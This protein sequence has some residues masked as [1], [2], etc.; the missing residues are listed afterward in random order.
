[1]TGTVAFVTNP[2]AKSDRAAPPQVLT[3]F[4][5]PVTEGDALNITA[6]AGGRTVVVGPNGSGKS[7]LGIRLAARSTPP[8]GVKRILGHRRLWFESA[9][10][11]MTTLNRQQ[12]EAQKIQ[13]GTLEDLRFLDRTNAQGPDLT[14]FD[15]FAMITVQNARSVTLFKSGLQPSEVAAQVGPEVLDQLNGAFGSGNI[16][17]TVEVANGQTL[18]ATK[19]PSGLS[20]EVNS[21][22]DGEKSI[23]L[24]AGEVLTAPTSSLIVIDEPERHLHRSISAAVIEYLISCRADAHFLVLTHDLDLAAALGQDADTTSLCLF[25]CTWSGGV[26]QSW[27]AHVVPSGEHLPDSVRVA[28]LGGRSQVLFVEGAALSL[29]SAIYQMLFPK[30]VVTPAGGG[31]QVGQA[32]RGL[33]NSQAHHWLEARGIVDGDERDSDE[34]A[35]LFQKGIL[36]L[37]VSEIENLYYSEVVVRAVAQMQALQLELSSGD[38]VHEVQSRGIDLFR[39]A[40]I[41]ERLAN[42]FAIARVRKRVLE[43]IPREVDPADSR[44][45][46]SV[47]HSYEEIR[48][49][50]N[51]LVDAGDLF[52]LSLRAPIRDVGFPTVVAKALHFESSSDY[53]ARARSLLRADAELAGALREL[54]A[55]F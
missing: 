7:A 51:A 31:D 2:L 40:N 43:Q 9:G 50:L 54:V 19:Q 44:L 23:F 55:R 26:A 28:V 41:V 5:I 4:D 13:F 25:E 45:Q 10:P 14:L 42:K 22:S 6:R 15:V 16:P 38:L 35:I 32:V 1:M 17:I 53:E 37:P 20:Y 48:S 12:L 18:T 49:E 24:L 39:R 34:R 3:S 33:A 11:N 30:M 52:T 8:G 21:M 29:D 47:D 27:E 46:I 36:A